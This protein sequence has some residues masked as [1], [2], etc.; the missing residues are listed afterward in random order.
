MLIFVTQATPTLQPKKKNDPP[1]PGEATLRPEI[2]R[3]SSVERVSVLDGHETF[4]V[5]QYGG[6]VCFCGRKM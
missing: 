4:L 2:K 1:A 6:V 5:K 3:L